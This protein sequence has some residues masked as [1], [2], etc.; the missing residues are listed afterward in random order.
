MD[1]NPE[2]R[3]ETKFSALKT[4]VDDLTRQRDAANRS[5]TGRKGLKE[6]LA[7]LRIRSS[8]VA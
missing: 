5:I 3:S 7:K 2:K 8:R 1:R 6:K 4:Y